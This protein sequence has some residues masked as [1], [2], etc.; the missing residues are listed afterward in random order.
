MKK[1]LIIAF[2]V[3][4]TIGVS[5]FYLLTTGNIGV[6]YNTALVKSGEVSQYVQD[7]GRISSRNIRKYHGGGVKKIEEMSLELGDYVKKG[8]LLVKYE[9]HVDNEVQKVEKQIEALEAAYNDAL[10]GTDMERVSSARIE[11][12]QI[13]NNLE[14]AMI[15]KERTESLYSVGAVSLSDLEQA[16]NN[17]DQ[18][19]SSLKI[20]QNTYN[21]LA[22]GISKNTRA[23]YE[24]EIDVLL[25]TLNGYEKSRADYAIYSDIEGI[26]TELNTFKGDTPSPGTL[27]IE[28]QDTSEKI[29]LVDFMVADAIQIKPDMMAEV[30][31]LNLDLYIKDLKVDRVYPKAFVTLSELSVEENRQTVEIGLPKSADALPYGLE[32]ETK[33]MIEAPREVLLIPEGAVV[34]QNSRQ[35]VEVLVNGDVVQ[36]EVKTGIRVDGNIEVKEGL[37]EGESVILNYQED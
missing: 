15:N 33:V 31:D 1:K 28:I 16:V 8:Q 5:L 10:S 22:K 2:I 32:V 18:L 23:K 24:A 34:S 12:S 30:K 4:T 37:K 13:K 11:L 7:V 35:Y 27:M 25:L 3:F 20:A 26:V 6:K 29:I 21:Q 17:M 9:D 36:K 14:I 19:Q